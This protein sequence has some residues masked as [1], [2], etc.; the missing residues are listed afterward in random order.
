MHR[1]VSRTPVARGVAE[2]ETCVHVRFST[3]PPPP[4]SNESHSVKV[5]VAGFCFLM[6]L[7]E[8]TFLISA[9]TWSTVFAAPV[10]PGSNA[11]GVTFF[12]FSR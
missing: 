9:G 3:T 6:L 7:A 12:R 8:R 4:R 11:C 10:L 5:R 1:C 2:R